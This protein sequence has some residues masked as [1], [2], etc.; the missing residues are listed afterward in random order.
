MPT[1][2]PSVAAEQLITAE[3]I[4]QFRQN[5]FLV[6]E[7]LFAPAQVERL[8]ARF[9][10]LYA[11]EFETGIY[12]DEW[13]WNPYLGKPGVA[14]QMTGVW[15]CDRA[16][17]TMVMSPKA[18]QIA[19]TLEGWSGTRL[20]TDG[21]WQKPPTAK[22][23]TLHQDTMYINSHT[24]SGAMTCWVALSNAFPG[25]STIEYVPGSHIWRR[26]D[27]VPEFHNQDKSYLSQM[28]EAAKQAGI[29][30]T[31]VVQMKLSPGSCVFHHGNIWHGS[32]KNVV[33]VVRR[34][35]VIIHVPAEAEFQAAGAY[36]PG[37]YIAGK[38]RRHEDNTMDES[39]FPI[40]WHENGY[41]T[42]FLAA[43]DS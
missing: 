9:D 12:P 4:K 28:E 13:H 23:T 38:Y 22:E 33:D 43:Y 17:A 39:F 6:V 20:L 16:V 24:P 8:L 11:G 26:S 29:E 3:Q 30:N 37:G 32:G 25:A 1:T 27:A 5:G 15:R 18:A 41:R 31:E 2:Q 34:S 14:G 19:A 10:P 40:V 7:D 42:P 21:L 36:I 35:L